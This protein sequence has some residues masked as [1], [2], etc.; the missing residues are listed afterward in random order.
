M[1]MI[2]YETG[3]MVYIVGKTALLL[4]F[5]SAITAQ[6]ARYSLCVYIFLCSCG[7]DSWCSCIDCCPPDLL[8]VST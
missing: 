1:H 5:Y 4:Y 7:F 8:V 6:R 3:S 2:L